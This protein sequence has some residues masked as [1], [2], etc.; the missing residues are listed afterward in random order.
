MKSRTTFTMQH[1]E[2]IHIPLWLLKD[3]CWMMEW[4]WLGI[5]MI[6]PTIGVAS[7]IAIKSI[8]FRQMWLNWAI[9][10][11]IAANA[12]WMCA[13]FFGHEEK[14]YY[15]G[16]PFGI[17]FVCALIFYLVKPKPQDA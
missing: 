12:F 11:W 15:A 16:I 6:V 17:G 8:G 14:K 4:K 3:T 1:F 2:N 9:C 5:G 10:F 13:E 7:Y